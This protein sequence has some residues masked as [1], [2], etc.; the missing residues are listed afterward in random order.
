MTR[1]R[2]TRTPTGSTRRD[3]YVKA[4]F[5]LRRY[6]YTARTGQP[7]SSAYD[8]VPRGTLAVSHWFDQRIRA[9]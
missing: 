3:S 5:T 8:K 1:S 4:D 7:D 9:A 6:N 2:D